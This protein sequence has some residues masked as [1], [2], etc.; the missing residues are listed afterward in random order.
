MKKTLL[1]VGSVII[2]ILAA[3]T[4]IFIPSS[5]PFGRT[6]SSPVFGKYDGTPIQLTPGS[7]FALAVKKY[8]DKAQKIAQ[9][10]GKELS[11]YHYL[12]IYSNA[13][14]EAVRSLAF[15]SEVKKSGY[16]PSSKLVSRIMLNYFINPQTGKYDTQLYSLT[17]DADKESMRS[18]IKDDLSRIQY[19][20]DIF[21][22]EDKF[23]DSKLFGLKTSQKEIDFLADMNTEKRSFEMVAFSKSA[24]P[25]SEVVSFAKEHEE[26]FKKFSLSAITTEDE[27]IA[28]KAS[29]QLSNGERTFED[30]YSEYSEKYYTDPDSQ[31]KLSVSH[32]YQYQ[33]KNILENESD[34]NTIEALKKGAV[35]GVIKT[36]QGY[37][38][39]RKDADETAPDFANTETIDVARTYIKTNESSLI[40]DYFIEK[41]KQFVSNAKSVGFAEAAANDDDSIK[42]IFVPEFALNYGNSPILA[43]VPS[44]TIS[45][46]ASTSTNEDFLTKAFSLKYGE[47]SEPIALE[48]NVIVLKLSSQ[49]KDA[50]TEESKDL[51]KTSIT[52]FDQNDGANVFFDSPKI[53]NNVYKVYFENYMQDN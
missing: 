33:L 39:F 24:Y 15:K 51:I 53:E 27:S 50:S 52:S 48:N 38:I 16:E 2:L 19:Y 34:I 14:S 45:E 1:Y 25:D 43:K 37:T 13:F 36:K 6:N 41:A 20:E 35:S 18:G 42:S 29:S 32:S 11:K 22:S 47:I 26:Y 23:G 12:Q 49:T 44:D 28:K 5:S 46:L 17:S 7:D 40:E 4:F 3:V 10:Q 8:T 21:G 9:E 31:G 30:A